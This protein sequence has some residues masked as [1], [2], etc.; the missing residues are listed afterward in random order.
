[1]ADRDDIID[2]MA[3]KLWHEAYGQYLAK[4]MGRHSPPS[5]RFPPPPPVANKAAIDLERLYQAVNQEPLV[6]LLGLE[7]DAYDRWN[8]GRV[9]A[10]QFGRDLAGRALGRPEHTFETCIKFP[11]F[12]VEFDGAELTWHGEYNG[13]VPATR[14]PPRDPHEVPHTKTVAE[15]RRLLAKME[16]CSKDCRGWDIFDTVRGFEIQVCDECNSRSQQLSDDDVAQL[17]EAKKALAEAE[18]TY[19]ENP[20]KRVSYEQVRPTSGAYVYIEKVS[21]KAG[22]AVRSFE[23]VKLIGPGRRGGAWTYEGEDGE[24]Y[25]SSGPF[26]VRKNPCGGS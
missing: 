26:Y 22:T 4:R 14:N 8:I 18:A 9:D 7:V 6:R 12:V 20:G 15:T 17:P 24:L 2:G 16:H 13:D 3:A 25:G 19:A 23:K 1:M 10:K 11:S 21:H 5:R